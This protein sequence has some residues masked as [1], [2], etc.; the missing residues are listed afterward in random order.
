MG[1]VCVVVVVVRYEYT[2]PL[3]IGSEY[4]S[5]PANFTTNQTRESSHL[6]P[7]M[8]IFRY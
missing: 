5:M 3:H 1:Y 4:L 8:L 6:V 2:L 7:R